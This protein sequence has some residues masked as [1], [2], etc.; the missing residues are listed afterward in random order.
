[1]KRI[2]LLL[3]ILTLVVLCAGCSA[4]PTA[5]SPAPVPPLT[6]SGT[7]S[8]P[9]FGSQAQEG[10]NIFSTI[11]ANCHGAAGQGITA[12]AIIGSG[13]NLGK[14]NTAQGLFSFISTAMP[15]SAPGSLSHQDY[16]NVLCYLLVQ[17]NY[18]SSGTT[19]S[20]SS[21]AAIRLN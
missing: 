13:S 3:T 9:T 18:A 14:Y 15:F 6:T 12:P 8:G 16:L 17:D 7:P 10:Q 5:S 21:L 20:E 11:C 2:I 4:G 1:L 19:F